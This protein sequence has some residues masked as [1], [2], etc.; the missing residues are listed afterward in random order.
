VVSV[1]FRN[2]PKVSRKLITRGA[3]ANA[4]RFRAVKIL[5]ADATQG[6]LHGQLRELEIMT[7]ITD[8]GDDRDYLPCL[9]DHFQERGPHGD[10]LCMVMDVFS[11]SVSSLRRSAPRKVL[12]LHMAK[13]IIAEVVEALVHLHSLDIIHTG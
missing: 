13:I 4:V 1:Q 8:L 12:P 11:T 7:A 3:D 6:H 2:E 10:H 9:H 5:T